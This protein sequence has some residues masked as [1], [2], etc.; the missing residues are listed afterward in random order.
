MY[1]STLDTKEVAN[2]SSY[3]KDW[4]NPCGVFQPLHALNPPRLEFILNALHVSS[5]DTLPLKHKKIIDIGC[6]GGIVTEP[7]CRLGADIIGID[8]SPENIQEAQKH[9]TSEKLSIQYQNCTVENFLEDTPTPIYDVVIALEILEHVNSPEFFLKCCIKLLKPKGVLIISTLNRTLRSY[10]KAILAG[11]Y[12]LR[13]LPVGTHTW[14][15]FVKPSEILEI[16]EP[17]GLTFTHI[18]GFQ[19]NPFYKTW[20]LTPAIDTNYIVAAQKK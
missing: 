19:Y 4:W 1:K 10:M 17:N 6:G 16:L 14:H 20:T 7:L 9:A 5:K 15:K 8:A 11:E 3:A 12:L 2:F 18:N 13:F